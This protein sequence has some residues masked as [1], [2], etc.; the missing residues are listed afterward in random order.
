MKQKRWALLFVA[1]GL[2]AFLPACSKKKTEN[3]VESAQ[4]KTPKARYYYDLGPASVDVSGYPKKEQENY[5]LFLAICGACHTTARP[6][7]SPY[8]TE[9]QWRRFVH[10]MHLKMEGRGIALDQ[11][12]EEA[13]IGF[14]VYDS[15]V[16]KVQGRQQFEESQTR[17]KRQFEEAE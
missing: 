4:V 2:A 13:V 14:L 8:A 11:S 1:I 16:R 15:R 12:N 9:A 5:R 17:L 7:N 6:L 3:L 10:R